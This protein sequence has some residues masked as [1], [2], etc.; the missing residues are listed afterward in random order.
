MANYNVGNIE[1]GAVVND[2]TAIAKLDS[3]IS[4]VEQVKN[5]QT[6]NVS[7]QN[8]FNKSLSKIFP[9]KSSLVLLI[10]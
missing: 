8:A 6:K 9:R 3:L 7:Q 1:I 5:V 2:Q 10:T 4:K